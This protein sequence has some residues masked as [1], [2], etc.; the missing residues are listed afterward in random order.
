MW[1]ADPFELKPGQKAVD[2]L[3]KL[4]GFYEKQGGKVV[5]QSAQ[6][7]VSEMLGLRPLS[8]LMEL[9]LSPLGKLRQPWLPE[10]LNELPQGSSRKNIEIISTPHFIG[11]KNDEATQKALDEATQKALANSA[12]F[13]II[14]FE[15]QMVKKFIK[16]RL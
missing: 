10:S 13:V 9:D 11:V 16:S 5:R 6:S 2:M 7:S 12:P 3:P 4:I 15:P 14:N 8:V 1:T